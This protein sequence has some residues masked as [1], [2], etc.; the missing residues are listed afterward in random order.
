MPGNRRNFSVRNPLDL[1]YRNPSDARSVH[2][3]RGLHKEN[4][5]R[6][7]TLD[8]CYRDP[9]NPFP[10]RRRRSSLRDLENILSLRE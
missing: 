1:S 10:R 2:G 5:R 3:S 9:R 7:N 8:K 6:N 4:L